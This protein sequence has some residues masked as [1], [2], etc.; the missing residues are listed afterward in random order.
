MAI[1]SWVQ[2][3]R[4]AWFG[5]RFAVRCLRSPQQAKFSATPG[6]TGGRAYNVV[7]Y[8]VRCG[9]ASLIP[10]YLYTL[11]ARRRRPGNPVPRIH[12]RRTP[13]VYE[14]GIKA[15]SLGRDDD[16]RWPTQRRKE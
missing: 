16:S 1:S 9:D 13:R 15:A 10:G 7:V 12:G 8:E 2:A 6:V 5:I 11:V 14:F 3:A 4:A